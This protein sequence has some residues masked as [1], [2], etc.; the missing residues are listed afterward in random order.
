MDFVVTTVS[1]ERWDFLMDTCNMNVVMVILM[2]SLH[3]TLQIVVV[4]SSAILEF[5]NTYLNLGNLN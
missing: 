2:L 3:D 5:F 4:I 1:I